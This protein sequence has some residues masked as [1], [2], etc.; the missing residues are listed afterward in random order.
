MAKT[1]FVFV[2]VLAALI[3]TVTLSPAQTEAVAYHD[4]STMAKWKLGNGQIRA[5]MGQS[6]TLAVLEMPP[7]TL[8]PAANAGRNAH[9]HT[10]EQIVIGIGGSVIG[11]IGAGPYRLGSY[12]A[13]V[14]PSNWQ[15][16]GINGSV[17][18]PATLIEFQP[19]LRKNWFSP[20]PPDTSEK[21]AEPLAVS[22]D[23]HLF[24]DFTPSTKGWRVEASGASSKVLSGKT[25]RLTMWDLTKPNAATDL[26][27]AKSE[28]F[29]YVLEGNAEI[30][31]NSARREAKAETLA[32]ISSAANDVRLTSL[33]KGRTIVAV[34][35]AVTP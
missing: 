11:V 28:R 12:G 1:F 20:Y 31:V 30:T 32:V 5:V 4:F 16:F 6:G 10:Q 17:A 19:V 22:H 7:G 25:I 27:H 21:S 13:V 23:Q 14:V 29:V 26:G 18:E 35:E 9:H 34:F 24:E 2:A 8:G 33:G 15:H 3:A